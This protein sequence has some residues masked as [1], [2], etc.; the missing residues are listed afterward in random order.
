MTSTSVVDLFIDHYGSAPS[1]LTRAPGRV[2]LIGEHVDYN[3]GLALPCALDRFAFVAASVRDDPVVRVTAADLDE[4]CAFDLQT[5]DERVDLDGHPLPDWARFPVGVAWA[6]SSA[7]VDLAGLDTVLTSDVPIG[8][9]LASSAAVEVAFAHTWLTATKTELEPL[10][11]AQV[12][13]KAEN[14]YLGVRSGLMDQWTIAASGSGSALLL[15]FAGLTAQH[16]AIPE[17]VAVVIADSGI[18]RSL[19]HSD[20]NQRVDACKRALEALQGALPGLDHLGQLSPDVFDA[21]RER[22]PE[23]DQQLAEHVVYEVDRVRQAADALR[24]G[25]SAAFGALMLQSHASLRD[26]YGVS[27]PELDLLVELAAEQPGCYGARLT[28]AGFGGCTV[29]WVQRKSVEGFIEALENG[30]QAR[31]EQEADVWLTEPSQ[32]VRTTD[33]M[34]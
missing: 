25:D 23:S 5:L 31:S 7:G 12:C 3:G 33:L 9:G 15:D 4:T 16:L 19:S 18:R 2:N 32:G 14:E 24:E 17:D 28:G 21:H 30:Y 1:Y 26:L 27:G 10:A 34:G 20:Y 22:I 8:A 6:L 11:L 29:N 13:R